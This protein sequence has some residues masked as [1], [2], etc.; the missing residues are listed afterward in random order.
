M[1]ASPAGIMETTQRQRADLT[2]KHNALRG[3]H[4]WL[5]L[6]PA[7]SVKVVQDVLDRTPAARRVLEP[8][9][10]TGTTPLVAA[11]RGLHCE[12]FDINPFLVWF[13][14]VKTVNYTSDDLWATQAAAADVAQAARTPAADE[15]VPPIHNVA[16]WW[17]GRRAFVLGAM[18]RAIV[19]AF[20]E[21]L[22]ARDLL[23]VAF[24]QVVIEW[25]A[26]AF[27]HQSMSFKVEGL[28]LFAEDD[29]EQMAHAFRRAVSDV[30]ASAGTPV[31]GSVCIRLADARHVPPSDEPF[32]L[33][34]TSPPYPNRMSYIRE[35]RP[36]M[37][38]LGFLDEAREAGELDWQAIGGTWGIATSRVEKWT[39][40]GV[41]IPFEGFAAI[42]AAIRA[43]S[44]LLANYVHRYFEDTARHIA[45]LRPVLR[46]G[47]RVHYIVGNSKFYDTLVPVEAIYAGL[48]ESHGFKQVVVTPLRKRNSKKELVEFDVSAV[49]AD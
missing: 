26:A 38:W 21:P 48:L 46:P 9:C 7:Y 14:A 16:R 12:A 18:H 24:C 4:G 17:L 19:A 32:D 2:F 25:S 39:P 31:P 15:W 3:R 47:A 29:A 43:Q 23:L 10:G 1:N 27:N 35:L 33:V 30:I 22:P 41:P 5:R 44:G 11:E 40:S 6:T 37:Y 45:S 36:Y 8:F 13:A 34:V 49:A 28:D 42:L 20:P